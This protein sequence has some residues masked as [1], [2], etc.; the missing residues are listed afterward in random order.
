MTA[1]GGPGRRG[2]E[3]VAKDDR[4]PVPSGTLS[5]RA[6]AERW[7]LRGAFRLSRAVKRN[8][9]VVVVTIGDAPHVGMGE[10]VPYARYGQTVDT[11][12]RELDPIRT[13]SVTQA[14]DVECAERLLPAGA[15][16]NALDCALLDWRVQHL[17]QAAWTLLGLPEPGRVTTAY[18]L[19]IDAPG[20]MRR[21][22]AANRR[23]PLLKIKLGGADAGCDGERLR[24]VR[25]GSP[26]AELIVDANEGW[27]PRQLES[28][29]PVAVDVGVAM[30]EQ[31]LPAGGDETLSG[32]DSPV[33]IGAD[34][35]AHTPEGLPALRNKYQVVNIKLDKTGGLT[36]ALAMARAARA[37]G[38]E[39]MIGC[40][41]ATSLAMA[42]A[43][44]LAG[45]AR[46][47]DLDGPLLLN[48]DREPGLSYRQSLVEWPNERLWG[49]PLPG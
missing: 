36:A 15:A 45:F 16:R 38:F 41:V 26:G 39:V 33:P 5:V 40:M 3:P 14:L 9:D 18:T 23:R 29:L 43:L 6:R 46:F 7:P 42:P 37:Q 47:V 10:C 17:G 19:G 21:V 8:A 34:E 31:P 20:E 12:L 28:L 25:E 4:G 22:A 2:A 11:V 48:K 24:A 27:T 49:T 32:L 13:L 35:S 1:G 44:L 30:I